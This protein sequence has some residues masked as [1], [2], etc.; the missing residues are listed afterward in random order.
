MKASLGGSAV[1]VTYT[2]KNI[3]PPLSLSFLLSCCVVV[4]G[5]AIVVANAVTRPGGS[6]STAPMRGSV[7]LLCDVHMVVAWMRDDA[8]GR[9]HPP[10]RLGRTF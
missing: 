3:A 5:T 9:L 4:M 7:G 6:N 2:Y 10:I 8:A 1:G